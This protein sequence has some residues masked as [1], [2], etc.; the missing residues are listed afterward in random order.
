MTAILINQ[1]VDVHWHLPG[2]QKTD[3]TIEGDKVT[4]NFDNLVPACEFAVAMAKE[5]NLLVQLY[6]DTGP[7]LD[8]SQAQKIA[9][10]WETGKIPVDATDIEI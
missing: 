1:T 4:R 5:G 9:T 7:I 2:A 10:D 8:I 6:P 3:G